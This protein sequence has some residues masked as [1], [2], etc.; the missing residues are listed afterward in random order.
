[1]K[2]TDNPD[3]EGVVISSGDSVTVRK[4]AQP[5]AIQTADLAMESDLHTAAA[6]DPRVDRAGIKGPPPPF[7]QDRLRSYLRSDA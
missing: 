4:G 7:N 6:I 3:G 2:S 5:E 1:V